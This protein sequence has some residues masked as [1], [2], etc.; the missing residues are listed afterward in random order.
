MAGVRD[1]ARMPAAQLRVAIIARHASS[2]E[3]L[4]GV[5]TLE[6]LL[7]ILQRIGFR[8]A[9]IFA[10]EPE[11]IR[12]AI[13][14]RNWARAELRV[15]V[16]AIS[17]DPAA[18]GKPLLCIPAELYC[19]ARLLRTLAGCRVMTE[20]ID[21]EPP[22]F[23]R[24]LVDS[25]R[26]LKSGAALIAE[27]AGA[28]LDAAAFPPYIVAMRRDIRPVFFSTPPPELRRVAE[29]IILESAQNGTLD[30]PAMANAPIETWI[31]GRLSRTRIT[32]NQ[33]TAFGVFVA[34]LAAL[35]FAGGKLWWGVLAA[36]AFGVIDGLDGKQARVK[37]ETTPAG[38]HEHALD[39]VVETICW[40]ALAF[41]F[42]RS[43]QL[44]EAWLFF[45]LLVAAEIV[46]QLAK[47]LAQARI[48]RLLDD[49]TTFD[50]LVRRIG[51]RRGIYTWIM[52]AGLL[53]GSAP[54]AYEFCAWW[55]IITAV[56]HTI[57]A[58]FIRLITAREQPLRT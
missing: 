57:R 21:W 52:V 14:A 50:R 56:V 41:W 26:P 12:A 47:R 5:S 45:V 29:R 46:D 33:I 30:L 13:E 31:I 19:D 18:L 42:Q 48:D 40:A 53:G 15:K 4:C 20:L 37:I 6:R 9:T 44:P 55:G 43:G 38:K 25:A 51:A 54:R 23:V 3:S 39:F 24:P 36:L 8:E 28:A 32:P 17:G 58:I 35:L 16:M 10:A 22:E 2:L 7:R 27:G 49:Y 34:L 1:F 11:A